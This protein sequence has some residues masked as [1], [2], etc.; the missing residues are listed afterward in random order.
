M[1]QRLLPG[2]VVF[3][4]LAPSSP[5]PAAPAA[6]LTELHID[7]ARGDDRAPGSAERPLRSISAAL[8]RVP[9]PLERSMELHLAA[10]VHSTTGG[11]GMSEHSL[12]LARTMRPGAR[13]RIA[14]AK[15]GE[16]VTFDWG[17]DDALIDARSGIW[18]LERVTLGTY[19]AGQ[20]RGI[21]SSSTAEVVATDIE[22]CL[23]SQ[24]DAGLLARRG[25][26]IV[27]NGAIRVNAQ[28][29]ES[30]DTYCGIHATDQGVIEFDQR[31]GSSLVLGNGSL[32]ASYWGSIRLGCDRA[33]I[34]CRTRSNCLSIG[35]SGRIDL[36]NTDTVLVATDPKNTP[37]GLEDDGHILAEDAHIKIQGKNDSAIA[38]QKSST[39][40]CNDL[41]LSG[42]FEYALWAS[43]SSNFTGSFLGDIGRI[44]A[45]TAASVCLERI[46]GKLIGPL[47]AK[48]GA[49]ITT[50]DRVITSR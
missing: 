16:R 8:A 1:L 11:V 17:N 2:L 37:I 6:E 22:F 38:L 32:V 15:S 20:K 48:S 14:P 42:T 44:E 29:P 43:S 40:F 46:H 25:G 35:N 50:P 39:L 3:L 28:P 5:A 24:S 10:G 47:E 49:T 34:T 19:R 18:E 45:R 31:S 7:P 36:R 27:L 4:S 21:Q 30:G 9:E 41:E 12:A 26:R 33:S 23:R 13:V